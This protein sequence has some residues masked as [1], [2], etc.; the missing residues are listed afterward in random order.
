MFK[1]NLFFLNYVRHF[2]DLKVKTIKQT[3][4]REAL[5]SSWFAPILSLPLQVAFSL[6][7]PLLFLF[8]YVSNYEYYVC[9]K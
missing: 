3:T 6:F 7:L 9:N 1:L 2:Y 4:F 5:L 8:E